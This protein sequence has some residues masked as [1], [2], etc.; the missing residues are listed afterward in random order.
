MIMGPEYIQLNPVLAEF[1]PEVLTIS[2]IINFHQ[3]VFIKFSS[4]PA[5]PIYCNWQV[6]LGY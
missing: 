3:G 4:T 2:G 6:Q 5:M 1:N